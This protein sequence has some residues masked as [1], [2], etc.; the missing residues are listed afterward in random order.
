MYSSSCSPDA[1]VMVGCIVYPWYAICEYTVYVPEITCQT[2]LLWDQ[3]YLFACVPLNTSVCLLLLPLQFEDED[4]D[5]DSEVDVVVE[6]DADDEG[7]DDDDEGAGAEGQQNGQAGGDA[8]GEVRTN[9]D[10]DEGEEGGDDGGLKVQEID[11]YWLQRRISQAIG[12]L[13]AAAA[14]QLS[15]Q[16]FDALQLEESA[17]IENKVVQLLGFDH[18]DLA[19]ELLRN[20]LKV[21]WVIK[22]RQAQGDKQRKAVEDQMAADPATASIL[23]ALH[24]TRTSARDRQTAMERSIREEVRGRV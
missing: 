23:D 3:H 18:F 15:N 14:Q 21:V 12:N 4:E 8:V 1:M 20:R 13:D 10:V 24:A 9:M 22:L 11:A 16:V 17:S 7:D 6:S 2:P 5:Q 19:K